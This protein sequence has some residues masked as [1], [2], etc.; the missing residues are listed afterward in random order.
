M[1]DSK[2]CRY[3]CPIVSPP[4]FCSDAR[5]AGEAAGTPRWR[6][7]AEGNSMN[8]EES[9]SSSTYEDQIHMA[10]RE[11]A[12]FISAVKERIGPDQARL[13]ADDWL[14][15]SELMDSPP[16]STN[17]EWRAVTVAAAARLA[18]RLTAAVKNRTPLVASSD[19]KV[20][21]TPSSNCLSFRLL[22]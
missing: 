20:S 19:T 22:V 18:N 17:R 5:I 14:D 6:V 15:E 9:F 4:H 21:P 12:A 3:L 2:Y 7:E 11:L 8:R 13:S 16:R 10:E 1:A